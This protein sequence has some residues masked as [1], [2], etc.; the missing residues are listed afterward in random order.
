MTRP[1]KRGVYQRLRHHGDP[2]STTDTISQTV[3]FPNLFDKPLQ[4]RF[5]QPRTSSDGGAVQRGA[6]IH[7]S[8]IGA[9]PNVFL[10]LHIRLSSPAS[11]SALGLLRRRVSGARRR[12]E[13]RPVGTRSRHAEDASS[14]SPSAGR[15]P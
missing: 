12:E 4:A 11:L 5:D 8:A 6:L 1:G 13:E 10:V 9:V 15:L 2:C 3:L 7:R 14:W